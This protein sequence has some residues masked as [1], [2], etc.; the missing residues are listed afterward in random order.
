MRLR[1]S[2][3]LALAAVAALVL[4]AAPAVHASTRPCN[5]LCADQMIACVSACDK[6]ASPLCFEVRQDRHS[7][8]SKQLR[9]CQTRLPDCP[10]FRSLLSTRLQPPSR[11]R[12]EQPNVQPCDDHPMLLHR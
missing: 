11:E 10:T 8:N 7:R 3:P 2:L 9:P 5:S 12:R 4:L 1:L 6:D